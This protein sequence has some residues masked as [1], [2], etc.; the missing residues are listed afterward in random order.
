MSA[1]ILQPETTS[2]LAVEIINYCERNW[3]YP[4]EQL[5]DQCPETTERGQV[6]APLLAAAMH[7][8]NC[9]AVHCRYHEAVE[10]VFTFRRHGPAWSPVMFFKNLQCWKYQC[11]E[12]DADQ[13]PLFQLIERVL[14]SVGAEIIR[15]L[16]EYDQAGWGN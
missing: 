9:Y 2:R 15:K 13:K 10:D 7:R 4:L 12:G 11:S 3:R 16:P 14:H 1:F 5:A 8:L 6:T